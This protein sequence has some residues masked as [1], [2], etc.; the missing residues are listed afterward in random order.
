LNSLFNAGFFVKMAGV[1]ELEVAQERILDTIPIAPPETVGLLDAHQRILAMTVTSAI[2]LPA[3]DNSAMDG[4]A[5]RAADVA[6]ASTTSPVT[7]KVIGRIA[8]GESFT[9][10]LRAG[11]CVR[12]FTGSPLPAGADAVVMQE[13]TRSQPE[14]SV[15]AQILDSAKPWENVR[16]QGVD[17]KRGEKIADAGGVLTAG[18]VALLAATGTQTI[19]VGK[20]P[21]VALLAT[22]SELVEAG[23]VLAPGQIHE[24]NRATLAALVRGA[25]GVP[26]IFPI[27]RD[28]P[29]ETRAALEQAFARADFVV[30]SGGVSVGELDFVKQAFTGIGGELGFWK[31]AIR[32]GKPFVF[33]RLREKF[34]FGLPGNPVSAFVTF[35]LLVRPAIRRWQGAKDTQLGAFAATLAEPLANPGNRRHFVRVTVDK[36]GAARTAGLQ[37]SHALKSLAAADGLID[38]APG[39]TLAKSASIRVLRWD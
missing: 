35:L 11:E 36:Q 26:E 30:T 27:V 18:K 14:G 22:G 29:D 21:R 28:T 15:E 34:L 8:A 4:Y 5:V 12:L 37:E 6:A 38:L 2:D 7:L 3:F 33:G 19:S 23:S 16:L 31:V 10:E 17:V 25:G 13:D 9:G 32:P 39:L 20:C 24:S 1:I